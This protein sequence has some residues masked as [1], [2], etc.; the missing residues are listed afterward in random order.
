MADHP[1]KMAEAPGS[2]TQPARVKRAAT[3]FEDREGHR[4]PFASFLDRRGPLHPGWLVARGGPYAPRRSSR[5]IAGPPAPRLALYAPHAFAACSAPL[6]RDRPER[7][8]PREA[9]SLA[10]P[11]RPAPLLALDRRGPL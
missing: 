7:P 4:A 11:L 8:T 6:A 5:L 1:P 10:G 2:R 3:G 9:H